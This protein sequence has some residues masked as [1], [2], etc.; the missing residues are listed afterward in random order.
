MKRTPHHFAS[1][2]F[3]FSLAS[4]RLWCEGDGVTDGRYRHRPFRDRIRQ[5][6]GTASRRSRGPGAVPVETGAVAE[7]GA[8]DVE[9]A[10]SH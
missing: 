1:A 8:G 5:D 6:V 9:Q 10:V 7:H 2:V 3:V 4:F